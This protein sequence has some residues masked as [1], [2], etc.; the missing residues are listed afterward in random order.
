MTTTA[1]FQASGLHCSSCSMLISMNVEDLNGVESVSCDHATGKTVVTFDAE[2]VGTEQ[3][4]KS[5]QAAGYDAE[6]VG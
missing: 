2:R 5:I 1:T 4:R 3:I 6:L